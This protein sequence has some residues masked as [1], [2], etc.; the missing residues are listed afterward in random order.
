MTLEIIVSGR[1]QNVGFRACVRK[2]AASLG[3]NGEVANL[4]DGRVLIL[5]SADEV[6]L[7]KFISMLYGCPRAIIR[8]VFS[9]TLV[10]QDFD[11]FTVL[12]GEFQYRS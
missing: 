2:I 7:D 9:K 4:T 6:S 11:D 8:D 10:F 12:R 3:I 5:A 1:V